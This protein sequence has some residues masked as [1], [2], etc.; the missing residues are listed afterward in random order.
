MNGGIPAR[1]R[2]LAAAFTAAAAA[3]AATA[4]GASAMGEVVY[5][6]QP[7]PASNP[8]NVVSQPFEAAQMSQFGGLVE[9][10]GTGRKTGWVIVGMS[11]WACQ[12][13]SWT[14]TPACMS[15]MGAKF[16]WPITLRVYA[17]DPSGAVGAQITSMTKTFKL[18][19]RPSENGRFCKNEK[20]E[21]TG[22]WY[23]MKLA[24][25][26][27][28]KY[29]KITFGGLK[30]TWPSKAIVSVSYNTS[31][32]G[33]AQRPQPC[34]SSPAGCPY[35][36]LNVGLTSP[37]NEAEP[38][39]VPPSVGADPLPEAAYQNSLTP[40]NF[41]DGGTGG[42]GVFRL[43]SGCWTGHQPLLTIRAMN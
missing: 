2:G 21:P 30:M 14:G 19:Y 26:F 25:C 29:F 33:E 38:T 41:C 32:F 40:S 28:G 5:D 31:D 43:D 13:G 9:L 15:A 7:A 35:D 10:G 23:D 17:V 12:Q 22:A 3:L 6:N 1:A 11:S 24:R 34:N 20:G 16:E 27:H 8:G 42:T 18:P 39:P 36:S 4:T 37:P